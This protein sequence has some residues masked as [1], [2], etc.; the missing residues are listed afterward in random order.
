MIIAT[1][2]SARQVA[3]MADHLLEKLKAAGVKSVQI[4][5]KSA[6]DWV[7]LDAGDIIVHLFRP[8][9]REFYNIEKMWLLDAPAGTA[10]TMNTGNA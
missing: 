2:S 1:G 7:L 5:G 6:A 4:E 9:V 10:R 8:E 3:A